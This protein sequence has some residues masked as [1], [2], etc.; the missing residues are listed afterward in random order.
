MAM[1]SGRPRKSNS[2]PEEEI[3]VESQESQESL[4]GMIDYLSVDDGSLP[5]SAMPP[6]I[7]RKKSGFLS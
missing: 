5:P 1:R 3:Q 2:N 4:R 6:P 7:V